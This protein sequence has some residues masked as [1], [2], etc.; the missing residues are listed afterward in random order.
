MS[1]SKGIAT[2]F[3]SSIS[4]QCSTEAAAP[5]SKLR[6]QGSGG[7]K[8]RRQGSGG[9]ADFIKLLRKP[10]SLYEQ[11]TKAVIADLRSTDKVG[12]EKISE[13][14]TQGE[15]DAYLESLIIN[16]GF[17]QPVAAAF[18][19]SAFGLPLMGAAI[20][21]HLFAGLGNYISKKSGV[22]AEK[23]FHVHT[24]YRTPVVVE[25]LKRMGYSLE[26]ADDI[27]AKQ[28]FMQYWSGDPFTDPEKHL[29]N[30]M[31]RAFYP[32]SSHMGSGGTDLGRETEMAAAMTYCEGY[33]GINQPLRIINTGDTG[34]F[35]DGAM[36]ALQHMIEAQ[37]RGIKMPLLFLV[38]SNNSAISARLDYGG[39]NGED[40]ITRIKERF[41]KWGDLVAPGFVAEA[42]D[43]CAG[44]ES[45]RKA[46]DQIFETGKPS[47]AISTY[48]F[49]PGGHAS[50]GSPAGDELLRSQFDA[51]KKTLTGQLKLAA[52][53][54]MTGTELADHL[55]NRFEAINGAVQHALTGN[56]ILTREEINTLSR[57]GSMTT[58]KQDAGEV[59][60]L[61]ADYLL[62]KR[63]KAFAGMGNEI[64]AKAINE[65]MDGAVA[66]ARPCRYIH[67]E[68]HHRNRSDTRGGVYGELDKIDEKH[69]DN[70]VGFMPQEAQVVQVG[71]GMRGVHPE[72]EKG[73]GA[74]VFVK[75]PHTVF[76][77][78]A[79][80]HIKYAAFRYL[81]SGK[82]A[83]H[84]YVFDGGSLA[85]P[86]KG[87]VT[88]P[89]TG[90]VVDRDLWL[91]R[92]GEHHNT[93]DLSSYA[94]DANSVMALP[95]DMNLFHRMVPT[96]V[97]MHDEGRMVIS[98]VPTAAFGALHPKLP[99][100][101]TIGSNH[102]LLSKFPGSHKPLNGRKLI[103]I[104]Y[105][106]DSKMVAKEL[107][108]QDLE[109]ELLILPFNRPSNSLTRYLDAL[110]VA[111]Q[112]C[113][114]VVVDANPGAAMMAPIV[115]KTRENLGYPENM[116]FTFCTIEKSFVPY[117]NGNVLLNNLDV[118]QSLMLRGVI[119]GGDVEVM[120]DVR[121][122][123]KHVGLDV[124]A[125]TPAYTQAEER[126]LMVKGT[127]T[128]M[129]EGV[130]APMDGEGVQL[131]YKV[132]V[133]DVVVVDQLVAEME[134]DKATVEITAPSEGIVSELHLEAGKDINVT[135]ESKIMTLLARDQPD[136]T[137]DD[138][139]M[140]TTDDF[141][142][143]VE[144]VVSTAP[145]DGQGV[146]F[147]ILKQIGDVVKEGDTIMEA[148][149]DKSTLEITAA[150][151]GTV[152]QI[153]IKKGENDVEA[154]ITQL[155]SIQT[156]T[157]Q[158]A[159]TPAPTPVVAAP[160]P[161]PAAKVEKVVVGADSIPLSRHQRAMVQ[162][163]TMQ[164]GD[165]IPFVLQ[166][167][168]DFNRVQSVAKMT[169]VSPVAV[170]VR[171]LAEAADETGYN[172]KLSQQKDAYQN[173]SGVDVGVAIEVEGQLRVAVIRDVL[174]KSLP[175]VMEDIKRFQAMG[176]KLST[177]D[178]DMTNCC[179]VVSSMGKDATSAVIAV[180]PKGCTGI[181]GV[182]RRT[183]H[184]ESTLSFTICHA[185]L[186]GVQGSGLVKSYI[187]KLGPA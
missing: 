60:E 28:F 141:G 75:G 14:L 166:E 10:S 125:T 68:N 41:A 36:H 32:T 31:V 56:K 123:A 38:H 39:S 159:P 151:D 70:F 168:V 172:M 85:F 11:L 17:S 181:V 67:Q 139:F 140:T 143:S 154:G 73:Q 89:K 9:T 71:M 7:V 106:P 171:C 69:L 34:P 84:I 180:L 92:V 129:Q 161:T 142:T 47:W 178:Q 52:A 146:N 126:V 58:Y 22:P 80:D 108:E 3:A 66:D 132:A 112:E 96:M 30:P 182:G 133:G 149:T 110:A 114:V 24:Y 105:G 76:N 103:V 19:K 12:D 153:F 135:T 134:T 116:V 144:E 174:K 18:D 4:R 186:T 50:D 5:A 145:V 87:Q 128:P 45:V 124:R 43:P 35:T 64:Y 74:L 102:C 72:N 119:P 15:R 156:S 65:A 97:Q 118:R 100:D 162:N 176:A 51:Y 59:I 91:A 107:V 98:V 20:Y 127:A 37:E 150:A 170:L 16:M 44:V 33:E 82:R 78:H 83:N 99:F 90:E 2:N 121:L 13:L 131:T 175:D 184:G 157:Q 148:E 137:S 179:W 117:G 152:S 57:P 42:D 48:P 183:K 61:P 6:R 94:H 187:E 185:T 120:G 86:D 177:A 136:Q 53:P 101:Q 163:M 54:G 79:K 21:S 40:A 122:A 169:G 130:F 46:V 1:K 158:A 27:V 8:L 49:R 173:F 138:V 77:E 147:T 104:T 88:D 26:D 160:T 81:D 95:L 167:Q 164:G 62:G 113:E 29:F 115:F 165:T 63:Q 109:A 93:P 111:G 23:A 25:E 155:F 55:E